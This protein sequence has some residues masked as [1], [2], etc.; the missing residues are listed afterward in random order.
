MVEA[1][2]TL[3]RLA[4]LVL[5]F[6]LV[7]V[8]ICS[9]AWIGTFI[10]VL[11]NHMGWHLHWPLPRGAR[12]LL[13]APCFDGNFDIDIGAANLGESALRRACRC[14]ERRG[15]AKVEWENGKPAK[16]SL[17]IE[18]YIRATGIG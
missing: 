8:S 2:D 7:C 16:A 18:G 1:G 4:V 11:F 9:V 15:L 13:D 17:A 12:R 3:Y 10:Y 6:I 5:R 14:L